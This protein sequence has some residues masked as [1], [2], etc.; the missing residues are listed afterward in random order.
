MAGYYQINGVVRFS[1]TT[2]VPSIEYV[3]LFG[4]NAA[5]GITAGTLA[6]GTEYSTNNR[7]SSV[8]QGIVGALLYMNGTTDYVS[9]YGTLNGTTTAFVNS[10]ISA[11]CSL[12]GFLA[13]AA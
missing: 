5:L 2:G 8:S 11:R 6:R 3:E 13:R 7:Q 4:D 9:L 10:T 1:A 12:S